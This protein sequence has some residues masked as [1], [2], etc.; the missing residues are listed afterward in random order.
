MGAQPASETTNNQQAAACSGDDQDVCKFIAAWKLSAD[1][2][3]EAT[4]TD[5][6]K[7]TNLTVES[8]QKGTRTHSIMTAGA[9]TY[10]T[11][12]ID[13]ATYIKDASDGKWWKQ[14]TA[15]SQ[16]SATA[17]EV[18]PDF[19]EPSNTDTGNKTEYKK[20]GTE[21]CG[22]RTC[23]KYQIVDPDFPEL[24]Q[25]LWFDTQDYLLR[26]MRTE[27]ANGVGD[28]TYS[29]VNVNISEPSPTKELPTGSYVN[30]LTG[31]TITLPS[32]NDLPYGGE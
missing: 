21:A 20:V 5:G 27:S 13:D 25:Y 16:Q 2:K 23:L 17:A 19:E 7:T 29:Y 3:V 9:V 1:Y 26:R 32:S 18:S 22:D 10:E 24:T 31:E 12:I 6:D 11:I 8:A 28:F 30:P 15:A 4:I 14:A